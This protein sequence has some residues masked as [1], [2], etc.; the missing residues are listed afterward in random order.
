MSTTPWLEAMAAAVIRFG[1]SPDEFW[2]L[3]WA[4]WCALAAFCARDAGHVPPMTR[5]EFERLLEDP[6]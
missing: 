3:S 1:L 2:A 6:K 5:A 4:E